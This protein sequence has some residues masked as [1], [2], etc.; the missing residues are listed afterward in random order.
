MSG[1]KNNIVLASNIQTD[2][3]RVGNGS[4]TANGQLL[5]GGTAD[6]HMAVALPTA[7]NGVELT[8]GQNSLAVAG[9]TAT[10]SQIGVVTLASDAET[11]EGI[12]TDK[13]IVPTGLK[14]KLGA[15]TANSMPYGGG[16]TQPLGWTSALTNGQLV[17][18]STGNP[19]VA[20]TPTG[21]NGVAVN[22][23][24]GSL[25]VAGIQSTTSQ[26]GVVT[27]ASD[28]EAIAGA[29][30]SKVIV[31]SS[32]KAKLGAQT[33]NGIAYGGGDTQAVGWTSGMTNGQLPIGSTGNPPVAAALT[34]GLGVTITNGAGS[35]EIATSTEALTWIVTGDDTQMVANRGYVLTGSVDRTFT[36]PL[37]SVRG[38]VVELVS[39]GT[40]LWT[41]AQ[42][43][44][45]QIRIGTAATTSGVSGSLASTLRGDS[46][47]IL[48][49][50][51]FEDWIVL[52]G[53]SGNYEVV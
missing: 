11:I 27:L 36:L 18:G 5:I 51:D 52:S 30:T 24:A 50:N 12:V 31:P 41:I 3:D 45:Q 42:N 23:G 21:S 10:T 7:S 53:I 29:D 8:L 49:V 9:I 37:S 35:I 44:E 6:P 16:D 38:D 25:E 33:A 40:G 4:F 17:V 20:A 2:A 43:A 32:L 48:C 26:V 13:V 34:A 39:F 28:A 1:F 15:Q 22:L 47:R 46:I 19:P 14:A